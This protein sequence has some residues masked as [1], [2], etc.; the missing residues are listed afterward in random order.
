[1]TGAPSFCKEAKLPQHGG[2]AGP[3]SDRAEE[4]GCLWH[5]PSGR[6]SGSPRAEGGRGRGKEAEK[7]KQQLPS[8][9]SDVTDSSCGEKT[10]R[11]ELRPLAQ[12][13]EV[14][15]MFT[16]LPHAG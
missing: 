2:G 3:R 7:E 14:T 6:T 10:L 13:T 1:M 11:E 5:I 4:P 12:G 16:L 8:L 9:L 15:T